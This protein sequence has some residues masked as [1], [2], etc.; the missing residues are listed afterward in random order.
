MALWTFK[1]NSFIL[2]IHAKS[3]LEI[4][5]ENQYFYP[6]LTHMWASH[7]SFHPARVNGHDQNPIPLEVLCQATCQHVQCCLVENRT[8]EII[9]STSSL[10]SMESIETVP[11]SARRVLRI[12]LEVGLLMVAYLA[13]SVRIHRGHGESLRTLLNRGQQSGD[14]DDGCPATGH[15]CSCR[16]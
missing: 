12:T 5:N 4:I 10:F 2:Q 16:T 13:G 11:L 7:V 14:V 3:T 6:P 1:L 15:P 8:T 9:L